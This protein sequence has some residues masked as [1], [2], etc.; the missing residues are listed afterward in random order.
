MRSSRADST[1]SDSAR[2]TVVLGYSHELSKRTDLYG[3]LMHDQ[4]SQLDAGTT[5]AVGVRHRF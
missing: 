1:G 5:P 2:R 3:L 4:V